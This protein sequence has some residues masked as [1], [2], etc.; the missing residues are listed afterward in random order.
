MK[1][2]VTAAAALAI[3]TPA[4]A[5]AQ[6]SVTL[7]GVL[8]NGFTYLSN[9]GGK[10]VYQMES[11]NLWGPSF[12]VQGTEDL[13][14]GLKAIFK[15]EGGYDINSGRSAQG[16]LMF[17]R[18]TYVGLSSEAYGTLTMG[19]QYD[20]MSDVLGNYSSCWLYGGSG[21]HFNDNDNVCQSVRFNNAVKYKTPTFAGLTG[22][23][24]VA[25]GNQ[26]QFSQNRA[27]ALA[28]TYQQ[29][30]F[31]MGVAYLSVNDAGK[32]GGPFDSAGISRGFS[33]DPTG[34]NYVGF[35]GGN[36]IALQ[37][38]QKWKVAGV[39][40]SYVI[41]KTT[42]TAEYTN[43]KYQRSAYLVDLGG[44]GQPLTDITFNN[45]E[46]G[47]LY[48]V[49]PTF[50][51]NA[52]YTLSTMRLNDVSRETKFH[53]FQL[54]GLYHLSKRTDLYGLM[55][56]QIAAGDATYFDGTTF[57]QAASVQGVSTNNRQLGLSVG[58][59]STF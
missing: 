14:G 35:M 11:G 43:S 45:W 26:S 13:G 25:L 47:A 24:M 54:L 3:L 22:Y 23:G 21:F 31:S 4:A 37:D 18:S 34:D 55:N 59:R 27:F 10:K 9:V 28:G 32:A 36:Y 40:A 48:S 2:L 58:I 51:V 6:S 17:G 42:L 30:S 15:I 5:W 8:D 44:A 12:G 57:T 52:G 19:R 56:Y 16:G 29:G 53:I 41:G 20:S 7:Y 1:K 33:A 39:G 38:A 50:D 49:T 46:L